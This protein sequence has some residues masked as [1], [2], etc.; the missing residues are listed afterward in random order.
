MF[1]LHLHT[2]YNFGIKQI[3]NPL[4][5]YSFQYNSQKRY[6]EYCPNENAEKQIVLTPSWHIAKQEALSGVIVPQWW[7]PAG[8]CSESILLAEME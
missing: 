6:G 2:L 1:M 7:Y 4:H 3:L 5:F 8:H